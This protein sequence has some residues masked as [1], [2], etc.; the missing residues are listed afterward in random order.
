MK[1]SS[2]RFREWGD[3][4]DSTPGDSRRHGRSEAS[5]PV[6]RV[7][8]FHTDDNIEVRQ[9]YGVAL[10]DSDRLVYSLS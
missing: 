6:G 10:F 3:R 5:V 1:D 8:H 2:T 7:Q 9:S 4:R